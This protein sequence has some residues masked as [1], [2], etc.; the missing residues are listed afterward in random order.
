MTTLELLHSGTEA[1]ISTLV[2]LLASQLERITDYPSTHPTRL[3]KPMIAFDTSAFAIS[4]LPAAGEYHASLDS[5][6]TIHH[7]R[8]DLY[9]LCEEAGV[10]AAPRYVVPSAHITIGRFL[11]HTTFQTMR[12]GKLIMDKKKIAHWL[13]TV[14]ALNL[15]LQK[16]YW[17][18]DGNQVPAGG[19]WTIGSENGLECRGGTCWYGGGSCK[20]KG[21]ALHDT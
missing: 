13:D 14:Q 15:W 5:S 12:N 20:H 17:P 11:S 1:D 21:K 9:H 16:E 19:Q 4:F 18:K 10:E 2:A 6:Y 7:L 3:V 8:K